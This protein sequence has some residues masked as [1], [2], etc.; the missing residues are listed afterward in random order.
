MFNIDLAMASI[1]IA[2]PGKQTI[3]NIKD[4]YYEVEITDSN[5]NEFSLER[6]ILT[7]YPYLKLRVFFDG[8]LAVIEILAKNTKMSGTDIV[9]MVIDYARNNEFTIIYLEDQSSV[10]ISIFN[11]NFRLDLAA[12]NILSSGKSWYNK[13]GFQS[14]END[15]NKWNIIRKS[16]LRNLLD[17]INEI[18]EEATINKGWYDSP[19]EIVFGEEDDFDTKME[20]L[21]MYLYSREEYLD[22]EVGKISSMIFN[23][24]RYFNYD[25]QE[26]LMYHVVYISACSWL[27]NYDRMLTMRV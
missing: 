12:I 14:D 11:N 19:F 9:N 20:E 4:E 26:L 3:R 25:D 7:K 13:L 1:S 15:I 21:I 27:L 23:N 2:F 6:N 8:E 10:N 24:I 16:T 22:I 5:Q 18:S 17:Q